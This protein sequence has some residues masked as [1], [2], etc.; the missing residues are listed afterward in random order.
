MSGTKWGT[1]KEEIEQNF[2]WTLGPE[3][4][5]QKTRSKYHTEPDKIKID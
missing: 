3:A 1:K 2:P 4:T 5:H